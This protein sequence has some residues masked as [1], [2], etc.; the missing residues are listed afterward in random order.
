M[1]DLD[2]LRAYAITRTFGTPA[3]LPEAIARLGFVQADP[4]R[5]PA[6]AQDLTLRHRVRGYRAG[7]LERRYASLEV[8]EDCLVNYGFVPREHLP[9]L[10]PRVPVRRWDATTRRRADAV[11]AFVHE[12]G[13][14]HPRDV[15]AHFAHGRAATAWGG[16]THATT[17]LLDGMHYRG[18]LRV[19]RRDNGVRVYVT[20]RHPPQPDDAAT[21]NARADALVALVVRKYAPLPRRSL[22]GLVSMLRYAVPHLPRELQRA[23][24]RAPEHFPHATV[25]GAEWFWPAGESPDARS[26]AAPARE[27]LLAPFDPLVWDRLRFERFWGWRYRFEAY[28]P[29]G[30]RTLGYYALPLLWRDAVVGWANLT[31]AD[32]ALQAKLGYVAGRPPR[33]AGFADALE[34]ELARMRTFLRLDAA[35]LRRSGTARTMPTA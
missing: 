3:T 4:I 20:H 25:D 29:P 11:L 32:G 13:A 12:R 31:V 10:H 23:L 17:R 19:A 35:P 7:D 9:L 28:V 18:L 26:R 30:K 24:A 1:L 33:E 16:S 34:A 27:R 15:A 6:R 14:V 21:R 22:V 8:E 2:G 5:A